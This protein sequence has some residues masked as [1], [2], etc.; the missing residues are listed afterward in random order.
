ML[1]V[2]PSA[3]VVVED[4]SS[5]VDAGIAA[6]MRVIGVGPADRVGHA[7]VR[8]DST[9]ELVLDDLEPALILATPRPA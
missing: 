2:E 9:R 8:V 1:G 6:G 7:H 3:C 4:A 5:G